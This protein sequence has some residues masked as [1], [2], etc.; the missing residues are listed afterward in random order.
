MERGSNA[1]SL[2]SHARSPVSIANEQVSLVELMNVLGHDCPVPP[3]GRSVKVSCPFGFEHSDYGHEAAF[4]VYSSNTGFCFAGH[5]FMTPVWLAAQSW[6]VS[7]EE[8]AKRLLAHI[9]WVD[10]SSVENA[11]ALLDPSEPE[12]DVDALREA[13]RVWCTRQ[14]DWTVFEYHKAVNEAL[15]QLTSLLPLVHDGADASKWLD[16]GKRV[17]ARVMGMVSR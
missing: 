12:V 1:H 4:R 2:R 15:A 5:G 9:G 14:D 17:M 10:T 3:E 6:D 7:P 8:A 16:S 11:R 13:L